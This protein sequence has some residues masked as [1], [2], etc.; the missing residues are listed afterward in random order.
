[1]SAVAINT[2]YE[3]L[4]FSGPMN[5]YLRN[6]EG[7]PTQNILDLLPENLRGRIRGSLYRV[8]HGE[9]PVTVRV[10]LID[11]AGRT[12][13]LTLRLLK[14]KENLFLV[15]FR[16]KKGLQKSERQFISWKQSFVP[17]GTTSKA[18]FNSSRV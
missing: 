8:I 14:V 10:T 15:T 1:M 13:N 12:K 18:I 6:P 4:Y 11:N 16:E 7:A 5:R 9:K 2:N 3:I 17:L